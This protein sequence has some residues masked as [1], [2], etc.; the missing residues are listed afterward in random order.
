MRYSC[1]HQPTSRVTNA[2]SVLCM[3]GALSKALKLWS[4]AGITFITMGSSTT[5]QRIAHDQDNIYY[6]NHN[7]LRSV[8][9]R[10]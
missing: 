4:L 7:R 2:L 5:M 9:L 6:H 3:V 10:W 8:G 1:T